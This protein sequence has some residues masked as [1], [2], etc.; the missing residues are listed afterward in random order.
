MLRLSHISFSLRDEMGGDLV[1][2]LRSTMNHMDIKWSAKHNE[3]L[4]VTG[5]E[6][7][8]LKH[9]FLASSAVNVASGF[10]F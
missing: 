8:R 2:W 3:L 7:P 4:V 5:F 6:K 1:L 10:R 9:F